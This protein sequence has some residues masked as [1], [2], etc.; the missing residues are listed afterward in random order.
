MAG[1]LYR[2][3]VEPER[4]IDAGSEADLE[5]WARRWKVSKDELRRAIERVGPRVEDVRQ[6][7]IGGFTAPGPTS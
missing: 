5:R 7:L 6:Y 4:R 2:S 3:G 1:D